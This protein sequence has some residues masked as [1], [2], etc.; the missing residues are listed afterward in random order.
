M[1]VPM[2]GEMTVLAKFM[3]PVR[4]AKIVPSTLGGVILAKRD[5]IGRVYKIVPIILN[6]T[7]VKMR[8]NMSLRPMSRFHLLAKVKLRNEP[9]VPV[10][11]A[12]IIIVLV[13]TVLQKAL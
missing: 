4:N 11:I 7:S 6:T 12:Q 9:I 10:I 8:K 2:P 13:S 1:K 3:V 5:M